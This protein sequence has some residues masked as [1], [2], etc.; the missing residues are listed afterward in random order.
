MPNFNPFSNDSENTSFE[1]GA[2][3]TQA[4][5]TVTNAV[6]AQAQ[7]AAQK[8]SD[9]IV[10]FLYAPTAP[11]EPGT[12]ET[13]TQHTDQSNAATRAVAA[14]QTGAHNG[15][16]ASANANPN[17][18]PD[19]EARMQ[20]IRSELFGNYSATF[21]AAAQNGAQNITTSIDQEMEKAR[22]QRE[23]AE[24]QRKQEEE[25]EETRRQEEAEAQQQDLA[26][27]AGK[28]TGMQTGKKQQQ[29]IALTQAK[30]KTESNR[31]TTG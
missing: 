25:E 27:P 7:A 8:A 11:S 6:A 1:Q 17:L 24:M 13:N 26:M 9:D 28:K 10:D 19:D 4:A 21:K 31:G 3:V 14:A 16:K 30:T 5:K 22:K 15:A 20:K 29:P 18:T 23:Q 12:D 2:P